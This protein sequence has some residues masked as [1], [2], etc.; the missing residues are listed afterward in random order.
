MKAWLIS[1]GLMMSL[2]VSAQAINQQEPQ[3][4]IIGLSQVVLQELNTRADVLA[5]NPSEIKAFAEANI[6]PHVDT[7][8]MAR[9]VVGRHWRV[10]TDEQ[11][12][13]FSEQFTLTIMRSYSQSLLK[14]NIEKVD[15]ATA[16]P[17]GDNRVIVPTKVK[18]AN[19]TTSEV[20]YRVFK[21][22]QTG[23]WLVYDI[24]VEGVSLLLNFRQSYSAD[25]EKNGLDQVILAMQEKNKSFQ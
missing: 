11:K 7:E 16:L 4:M 18:Q 1:L 20:S 14:L 15:V 23:H 25:I 24:V 6:L 12:K 10:A 3:Q 8:R 13:A 22:A 17:D 21:E 19:G 2:S 9:Y 5:E